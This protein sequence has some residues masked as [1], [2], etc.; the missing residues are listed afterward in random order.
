MYCKDSKEGFFSIYDY[1]LLSDTGINIHNIEDPI[2]WKDTYVPFPSPK[3]FDLPFDLFS[4]I[5]YYL[6]HY[7]IYI[8]HVAD[9]HGRIRKED[10]IAFRHNNHKAPVVEYWIHYFVEAI[11][12]FYNL[13]ISIHHKY[14][15]QPTMDIDHYSLLSNRGILGN[16]KG[17]FYAYKYPRAILKKKG[18]IQGQ[19]PIQIFK[20]IEE[21]FPDIQYFLLLKSGYPDSINLIQ[22]NFVRKLL[23]KAG[24][25]S[26][27]TGIHFSYYSTTQN[28]IDHEC[29]IFRNISGISPKKSR[30]HFLRYNIPYFQ[31]LDHLCI[32][33]DFSLGYYDIS[34]FITG[35]SRSYLWYNLLNEEI[36]KL[37]IQPF[38]MMD[39][40]YVYYNKVS[41]AEISRDIEDVKSNIKKVNGVFSI[42]L[43]NDILSLL[44]E[45]ILL[46]ETIFINIFS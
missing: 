17:K 1:G 18:W 22:E 5:F 27:R 25:D 45:E 14:A 7:D 30:A 6:T 46:G 9:I 21:V 23:Q 10:T 12:S 34:G 41:N 20:Y 28:L 40:M 43:H 19:D 15:L 3:G 2:I 33:E 44:Q 31:K 29:I 32:E 37:R 13:N 11:N 38:S 35:M 36:S 16:F 42:L 8:P 39:A 24:I 26:Q 4:A